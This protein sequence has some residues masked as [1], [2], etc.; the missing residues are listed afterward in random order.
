MQRIGLTSGSDQQIKSG[1]F[2]LERQF[3]N[4]YLFRAGSLGPGMNA[5]PS[6]MQRAQQGMGQLAPNRQQ[7]GGNAAV[8]APPGLS[9]EG[10]YRTNQPDGYYT[11]EN[12]LPVKVVNGVAYPVVNQ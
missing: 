9:S 3:A 12:G 4:N 10:S 11:D 7:I 2:A 1:L 8:S 5:N 6:L